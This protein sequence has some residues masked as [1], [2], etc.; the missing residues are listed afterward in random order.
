MDYYAAIRNDEIQP[1]VTTWMDLEGCTQPGTEGKSLGQEAEMCSM[2]RRGGT[3]RQHLQKGQQNQDRARTRDWEDQKGVSRA[4]IKNANLSEEM[5]QD[6]VECAT[7]VLEKYNIEKDVAA[8]IRK[9]FDKKYSPTSHYIA[10]RNFRSLVTHETKH[11]I[12]FCLGQV[13]IL[14]F[15][16]G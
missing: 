10:G 13:A 11:F 6:S 2:G 7:Q 8:H 5:Q 3:I 16:S 15:K 1:F 9:E 12:Y 4:T 14:L